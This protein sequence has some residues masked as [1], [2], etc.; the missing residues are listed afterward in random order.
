MFA[1][2]IIVQNFFHFVYETHIVYKVCLH[3]IFHLVIQTTLLGR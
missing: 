3:T 1:K 2:K